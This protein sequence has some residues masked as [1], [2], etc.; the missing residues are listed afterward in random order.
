[1][2]IQSKVLAAIRAEMETA[3]KPAR[4][5]VS[6]HGRRD[7]YTEVLVEDGGDL[8][9]NQEGWKAWWPSGGADVLTV[10][11]EEQLLHL[12]FVS[13]PL[14]NEGET[15][16]LYP[17][18]FLEALQ[19]VWENA[20]WA[21][22]CCSW[23]D[24]LENTAPKLPRVNHISPPWLR[25]R[26]LE[27][28]RLFQF[29]TCFLW[30]P[31]G[32]G[33]TTTLGAM[34]ANYLVQREGKVLLLS[35]TNSA[36]D[37]AL[38]E[39]DNA[40]AGMKSVPKASSLRKRCARIGYYFQPSRYV[41]REHL[42]PTTDTSLIADLVGLEFAKPD[43]NQPAAYAKWKDANDHLRK[44][45][46]KD[47]G[48]AQLAAMTTTEA[49]IRFDELRN[50]TFDLIAFD[51]ASQIPRAHAIALAPLSRQC[52]FAGDPKQLAPICQSEDLAAKE[53]LG[54]SI[55]E[56]QPRC[57]P[58]TVSLN[59]QSRMAEPICRVVGNVFYG[60]DLKVA[61]D[62]VNDP[63]WRKEREP[64][65]VS[66]IGEKHFHVEWFD[67][68]NLTTWSK[69]YGKGQIRYKSAEWITDLVCNLTLCLDEQQILVL[70]PYHSQRALILQKL[71][72]AGQKRV[73]IST[74]H[75]SQ[76]REKHT[77]VFD[78][79]LGCEGLLTGEDG[80]RLIN[81][82]ISRAQAAV[83]LPLSRNDIQNPVF[84][85]IYE[86]ATGK[87]AP[88]G[89]PAVNLTRISQQGAPYRREAGPNPLLLP[90]FPHSAVGKEVVIKGTSQIFVG[91]ICDVSLDGT[92]F[93]LEWRSGK[94]TERR[95][96]VTRYVVTA[97]KNAPGP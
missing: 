42:L 11:P 33:K 64:A 91:T 85:S 65:Y 53:W 24:G 71:R 72:S 31:P 76:G 6:S 52:I 89:T 51:E 40:L 22:K 67:E 66:G 9:E 79:V 14:P 92:E 94:R 30:G 7:G 58:S 13:G 62:K 41:G 48:T 4:V 93:H 60:G 21:D 84:A 46:S 27:S 23:V 50:D 56:Y 96:F 3:S 59:E 8:K 2:S 47:L 54:K 88:L 82:A 69:S 68:T 73:S 1:M 10:V 15:I 87:K 49:V 61:W 74:V 81:V 86:L 97:A 95:K 17:P 34:L 25:T 28:F 44:R 70:T 77:V 45:L 19:R 5:K 57:K 63:V 32:T 29:P 16:L 90:N 38:A 39:V 37:Q 80:K 26:Q 12:R 75:A 78:P 36:V 55:F 18:R 35:T 83:Y 20:S 43:R